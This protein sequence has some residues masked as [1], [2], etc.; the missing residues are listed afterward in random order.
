MEGMAKRAEKKV[1]GR[2]I[3]VM[4]ATVFIEE[5]SRRMASASSWLDLAS[6][7][8]S[9]ACSRLDFAS[10]WVRRLKI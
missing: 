3:I 6:S 8:L 10:W 5:L 1:P 7:M 9:L 2:K 4:M